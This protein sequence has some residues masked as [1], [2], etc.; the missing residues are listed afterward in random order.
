MT[1]PNA[2]AAHPLGEAAGSALTVRDQIAIAILPTI[3]ADESGGTVKD[4]AKELGIPTEQYDFRK[5]WPV[6]MARHAY[7]F[8]DLF[9]AE[10]DRQN[11][12][13]R[14][15]ADGKATNAP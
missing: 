2:P 4:A 9:L 7:E 15:R 5:H 14:P 6:L 3:A 1:T 12:Q 11:A 8:A 13:G 10:R